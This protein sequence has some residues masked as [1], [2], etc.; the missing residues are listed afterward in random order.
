M[1]GKGRDDLIIPARKTDLQWPGVPGSMK[2]RG[3]MSLLRTCQQAYE[4][5]IR[6]LYGTPVFQFDDS[7]L[8]VNEQTTWNCDIRETP[9]DIYPPSPVDVGSPKRQIAFHD[10]WSMLPCTIVGFHDM[11]LWLK[12]IGPLCKESIRRGYLGFPI[13]EHCHPG[14]GQ[15]QQLHRERDAS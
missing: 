13:S 11:K 7:E 8:I 6:I 10:D 9:F 1:P 14:T 4:E 2:I 5:G 12:S 15:Y 3:N